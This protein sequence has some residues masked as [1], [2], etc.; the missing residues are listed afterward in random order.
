[1]TDKA[2]NFRIQRIIICILS[3]L[4]CFINLKMTLLNIEFLETRWKIYDYYMY[5]YLNKLILDV[6][7]LQL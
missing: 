4:L 5:T 7:T 2:L 1:M 3:F 6:T